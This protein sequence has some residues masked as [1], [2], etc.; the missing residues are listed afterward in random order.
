M[1]HLQRLE[2]PH[3]TASAIVGALGVSRSRAYEL[4]AAVEAALPALLR[5]VGRPPDSPEP[6]IDVTSIVRACRDFA[7]DHPGAVG[8]R[9]ARRRYSDA[10]RRFI[11]DLVETR[12]DVSLDAFA[13]AAG[14][15]VA[16][17]RDWLRGGVSAT[18][19]PETLAAV[20]APDPTSPQVET[21]LALWSAW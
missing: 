5:P 13:D 15:P 19:S 16:T 8:G 20:P 11:L 17:L 12:R 10:F 9:G 7:Y 3:P 21:L 18:T 2:L 6:A 14:V 1:P 4:R